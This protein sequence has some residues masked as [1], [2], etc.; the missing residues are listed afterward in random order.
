MRSSN[1]ASRNAA[2]SPYVMPDR[3]EDSAP[4]SKMIDASPPA[5]EAN[6]PISLPPPAYPASLNESAD[7]VMVDDVGNDSRENAPIVSTKGKE[8]SRNING[9]AQPSKQ[10]YIS[11]YKASK[12]AHHRS[13]Q[14]KQ[15]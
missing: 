8:P 10:Q 13:P 11:P 1:K 7:P 15:W 6:G 2:N 4:P 9:G 14:R 12:T 3:V 5:E